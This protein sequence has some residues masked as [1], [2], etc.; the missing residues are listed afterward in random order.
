MSDKP[1]DGP[2]NGK[3]SDSADTGQMAAL[4]TSAEKD[5]QS[6]LINAAKAAAA[7]T[8]LHEA[9]GQVV[10]AMSGLPRYRHMALADLQSLVLDPLVRDRIAIASAKPDTG[11]KT[12]S[13][14]L[15]G[16]A[17]WAS[18]SDAVD[19]KIR[20]QIKAGVFP[21]RLKA[22]DWVSGEK[23]WLFD[24]IAASRQVASV[25]LANFQQVMKKPGEV[26]IHPVVTRQ[27]D[28]EVLKKMGATVAGAPL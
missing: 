15:A 9:F 8:R 16:L 23:V 21:V 19:E 10:L 3:A 28:P 12:A 20:E 26:H 1:N 7:R 24:V 11:D 18:V 13:A 5:S 27:I 17:I 22:E 4:Q 2:A 25:V 14:S 6:P